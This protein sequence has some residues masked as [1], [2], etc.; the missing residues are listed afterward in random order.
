MNLWIYI[1]VRQISLFRKPSARA[2]IRLLPMKRFL[3]LLSI[4]TLSLAWTPAGFAEGGFSQTVYSWFSKTFVP[5]P[6]EVTPANIEAKTELDQPINKEKASDALTSSPCQEFKPFIDESKSEMEKKNSLETNACHLYKNWV[7]LWREN[8]CEAG[9]Y[10]DSGS[11]ACPGDSLER[12]KLKEGIANE[13]AVFAVKSCEKIQE[14]YTTEMNWIQASFEACD[15][16]MFDAACAKLAASASE[17]E[18]RPCPQ[19]C[20]FH[21]DSCTPDGFKTLI[22]AIPNYFNNPQRLDQCMDQL[23]RSGI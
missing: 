9:S 10:A 3:L 20:T 23:R 17:C 15:Y 16:T 2:I 11:L 5:T 13:A 7:K 19:P 1:R 12:A 8:N 6:K 4:L 21:Y 14:E 18:S 22:R